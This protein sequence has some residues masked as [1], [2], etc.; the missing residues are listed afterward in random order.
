MTDREIAAGA[1]VKLYVNVDGAGFGAPINVNTVPVAGLTGVYQFVAGTA[2][3][4]ASNVIFKL[5]IN[6][7]SGSTQIELSLPWIDGVTSSEEAGVTYQL[8]L[9]VVNLAE[10]EVVEL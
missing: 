6:S 10:L 3:I 7:P 4:P 9:D 2:F 5:E 8:P 1:E